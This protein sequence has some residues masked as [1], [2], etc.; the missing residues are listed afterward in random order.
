M[1]LR[2]TA[3]HLPAL[4]Q[5]PFVLLAC[6]TGHQPATPA[7]EPPPVVAL[8]STAY[9]AA[10]K[11]QLPKTAPTELPGLHNVYHLGEN[12]VSGSEPHGE[13]AFRE[14]QKL[15]IR[16]ILSV[17]GKV[18][19]AELAAKY[20]MRYVHVPIQ[21]RG[22]AETEMMEIAKTFRETE[23]PFYV[24]CF[25][26]KH[27]GP[28]AAAVGRVVLDGTPREMAIAEM[29]QW[30]GTSKSYEGLYLALATEKIP[31]ARETK[32]FAWD[33]P[34]AH[35]YSGFRSAMIDIT[36]MDD[37]LKF[38]SKHKWEADPAHPDV[39]AGNE[40]TKLAAAF[41]QA[42]AD[43]ELVKKPADFRQWMQESVDASV[44][45]RDMLNA[46]ERPAVAE[47]DNSY[48]VIAQLCVSCHDK[49]RN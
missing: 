46:K 22:I 15:G 25:H 8:D 11:V 30:C 7:P 48:K 38:L 5:I 49:Y 47:L 18:P 37:N 9:E 13:E 31:S 36:R 14:L 34:A 35:R 43:P 2:T 12:I 39:H 45:L 19:D 21:Y 6:A 27:R 20:G 32:A 24:H 33:F 28:A 23:G 26:G 41:V 4:L 3:R 1:K 10:A 44:K 40:S 16:T 17:D 42:N 29:R